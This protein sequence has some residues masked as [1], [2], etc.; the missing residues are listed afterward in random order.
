MNIGGDFM[1]DPRIQIQ[2]L[3]DYETKGWNSK[4]PDLFLSIIHPDMVWPWP[5]HA[6]AHDPTDWVFELGH[7]DRIRWRKNWQDIFDNHDLIRNKRDTVKIEVSK[8]GDAAFAVVDID[9]HWRHKKTGL[10][11]IWKGRVCKIFTKMK[12]GEWKLI[13]HTGAL[14][15]PPKN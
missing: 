13:A 11:F 8:E 3:V 5:P 14:N 10:D 7:F 4:N 12:N 9:T 15:Y 2:A 1:Q 6:D